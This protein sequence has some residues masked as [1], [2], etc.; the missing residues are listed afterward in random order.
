VITA[1]EASRGKPDPL[2]ILLGLDA[3]A[4]RNPDTAFYVGDAIEDMHAARAAGVRG[5]GAAYGEAGPELLRATGAFGVID[6]PLEV[7]TFVD[8]EIGASR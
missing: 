2:P 4:C 1:D 8:A 5:I 7:L 3:A 6:A